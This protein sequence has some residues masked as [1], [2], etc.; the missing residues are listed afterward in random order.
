MR[1]LFTGGGTGGHFFPILAVA[2]ELKRIAEEEKILDLELFYMG[3]A[4]FEKDLL[5][6]E[7]IILIKIPSGK[8]RRYFSFLNLLDFFKLAVGIPRAIWNMFL[9]MPDVIFSKGGYGA[10]PALVAARLFGIPVIIHDSDAVPGK[11]SLFSAKFAKRIGIAFVGAEKFFPKDKTALVGVPIR[12][13]ILGGNSKEARENLSIFTNLP[14]LG[15]IGASQGS[16]KINEIILEILEDLTS[17]FEVIHQTG[18]QN[19]EN[20]KAEA[21]IILKSGHIKRYH[22]FGFLDEF[23]IRDFYAASDLIISRASASSI[24][25]IAA[26][27]KPSIL[28]PLKSAA[29]DHQ[30]KNAYEYAAEG[31]AVVIEEDNLSPHI[32]LA[33]IKKI[34]KN[35]EVRKKMSQSAKKFSRLDSAE[36]IAREIIK[37]GF[38]EE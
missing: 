14:I 31:A 5:K 25:E 20:V 4:S 6:K 8:L 24:F 38:H 34:A 37:L 33:E 10:F 36:I 13:W 29:Q 11:V 3:P 35:T 7:E 32:L 1:I 23:Q 12:K 18:A 15:I 21:K 27:Q 26:W 30:R 2:R 19:L 9:I 22:P 17:E 16:Q 28:I